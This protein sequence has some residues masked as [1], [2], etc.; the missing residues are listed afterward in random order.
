[1]HFRV[2][3]KADQSSNFAN[4]YS[5]ARFTKRDLQEAIKMRKWILKGIK[6]PG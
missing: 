2:R 1:M 4:L 5:Y 3:Y 6:K